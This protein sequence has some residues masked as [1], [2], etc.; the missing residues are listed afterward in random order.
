MIT[1]QRAG[2][3]AGKHVSRALLGLRSLLGAR[4]DHHCPACGGDVVGFFR[5]GDCADW[6]CP[7][8]G[9]SP[10]ERLVNALL[11]AGVLALPQS[12]AI[13]HMAPSEQSLVNRFGGAAGD[14]VPA[15][16]DPSRYAILGVQPVDLMALDQPSRFDLFYA[17][18]V[19]EHVPDDAAVLRNIYAS[20]RPGGEAWLIV[21]LW[22]KRTED[23]QPGMSAA[24]RERRFG[25]WD[26]VRQYGPDFADRIAAAGFVV[27]PIGADAVPQNERARMGLG[28]ILFRAVKPAAAR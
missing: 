10:R 11:D 27:T 28:E 15:D 4:Q 5:Y 24:E 22:D 2:K 23:G 13:L 21:P 25:Q 17:S 12:G 14:Y 9:A 3:A 20:L 26:H 18:H 8:C 1:A 7:A 16:I 6:G 19:M